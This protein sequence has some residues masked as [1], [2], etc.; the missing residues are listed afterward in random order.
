MP[1]NEDARL[2]ATAKAG[3]GHES[4]DQRPRA[5]ARDWIWPLSFPFLAFLILPL[6]ALLGR[7]PA[8]QLVE[9][10]RQPEVYQAIALSLNTATL[11]T[12]ASIAL[13]TPVA[14]LMASSGR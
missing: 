1:I 2:G 11:A 9:N 8:G 13:G 5:R 6:A 3:G 10:L 14:Y 4:T 12:V 7:A